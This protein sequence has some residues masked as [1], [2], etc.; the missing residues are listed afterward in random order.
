MML[1]CRDSLH[2]LNN[3]GHENSNMEAHSRASVFVLSLFRFL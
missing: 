1:L 3:D 2:N